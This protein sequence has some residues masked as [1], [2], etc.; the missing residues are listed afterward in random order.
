MSVILYIVGACIVSGLIGWYDPEFDYDN[1]GEVLV[2][3]L[4]GA[5]WPVLI[6]VLLIGC[7]AIIFYRV[8]Q[9]RR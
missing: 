9:D 3:G 7:I 8:K 2:I 5:V 1:I 6:P 4:F